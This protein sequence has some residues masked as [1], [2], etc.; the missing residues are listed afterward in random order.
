MMGQQAGAQDQLFYSLY[1]CAR[2][3]RKPTHQH[4]TW[5]L[6]PAWA[7]QTA[8]KRWTTRLALSKFPAI[9]EFFNGIGGGFNRSSG[10]A[11]EI[12]G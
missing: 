9:T 4:P 1:W 6:E 3:K 8:G 12:Y 2:L 7:P 10:D 11:S 5:H